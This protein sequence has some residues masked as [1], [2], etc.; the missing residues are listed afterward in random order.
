MAT[1]VEAAEGSVALKG[2]Q[3]ITSLSSAQSLTVPDG[4]A[5]ALI[6]PET[7]AVRFRDDGTAPTATVGMPLSVGATLKYTGGYSGLKALQFIEQT[8]SAK[9]NIYYF[10]AV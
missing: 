2:Y 9:L 3:Q 4:T 5:Y 8:A 1:K 6:T 7:Q 10:G